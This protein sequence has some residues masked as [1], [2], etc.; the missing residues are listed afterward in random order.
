[1]GSQP[2]ANFD[3]A[4]AMLHALARYLHGKDF[5]ALGQPRALEHLA[6]AIDLLGDRAREFIYTWSG[7]LEA[8]P[9]KR[10]GKVDAEAIARWMV[11]FYPRRRYP[12]AMIG[13]SNGAAVHL[14][15]AL[16]IPWLPQTVLIPVEQSWARPDEP[17]KDMEA[18]RGPARALLEANPDLQLHHMHDANQDRL[19][20]AHMT[21]FRVKRLRLGAAFEQF[22]T[23]TLPPGATIFLLECQRSWPTT[24]L[25]ERYFFQHGA[26]GGATPEEYLYGSERV[27]EYLKRYRSPY[28]RWES[29]APDGEQP[30]AEWGFAPALRADVERLAR[31]RGYRVQRILFT[32]PEDFSPLVADLYRWWYRQRHL[33]ANRLLVESFILLEPY[34]T[35]RTG[36]TPFWMLFNTEGSLARLERYL[37][38]ADAYDDIRLM[39]FSHGVESVGLPSIER[40]RA[41]LARACGQGSFVGVDEQRFPRDF[42]TFIRYHTELKNIPTRYPLPEP[43]ALSQLDAFLAEAGE[44]YHV[45]WVDAPFPGAPSLPP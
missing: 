21:Y 16:G 4:T 8:I 17:I 20:I 15:A 44:H 27:T 11:N 26:L 3:S 37:D 43:L 28:Q 18:A 14:C 9:P 34:W 35:L 25:G 32:E 22:L 30:E 23:E 39:L 33:P 41:V 36:S 2:V 10:L 31:Q 38:Q 7:W 24:Q 40:W 6:G 5:P 42:A 13:S 45:Q 29:P 19:M 12:A 1:M